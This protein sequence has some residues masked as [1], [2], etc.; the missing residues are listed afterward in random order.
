MD[1][2]KKHSRDHHDKKPYSRDIKTEDRS[3]SRDNDRERERSKDR[4]R[5]KRRDWDRNKSSNRDKQDMKNK[6][7]KYEY[8]L[9]DNNKKKE[10][11]VIQKE[12]PSL[13]VSGNLAKGIFVKS[14]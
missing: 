14:I 13:V 9:Q 2:S 5:E 11:E 3:R 8:G 7:I 4:D 1:R 6:E 10:K 12:E